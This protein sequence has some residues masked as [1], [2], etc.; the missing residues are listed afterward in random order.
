MIASGVRLIEASESVAYPGQ[1]VLGTCCSIRRQGS[2]SPGLV[3]G[4]NG[5]RAAP[6]SGVQ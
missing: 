4:G 1:Q 6:P 5:Q 2:K 3:R